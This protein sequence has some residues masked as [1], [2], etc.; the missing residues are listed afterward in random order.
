MYIWNDVTITEGA[1]G[2]AV[3]G[4][5]EMEGE[6]YLDFVLIKTANGEIVPSKHLI[7]KLG[8]LKVRPSI[9]ESAILGQYKIAVKKKVSDCEGEIDRSVPRLVSINWYQQIQWTKYKV[10]Y[11]LKVG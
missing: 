11:D 7:Y 9:I 3:D 5:E 4:G 6:N 10:P 8:I 2:P 1:A